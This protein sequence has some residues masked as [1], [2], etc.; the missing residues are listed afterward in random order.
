MS[1]PPVAFSNVMWAP[2]DKYGPLI[3]R[4][5]GSG[6]IAHNV[7][8]TQP[9]SASRRGSMDARARSTLRPICIATANSFCVSTEHEKKA[10]KSV[11]WLLDEY[12]FPAEDSKTDNTRMPVPVRSRSSTTKPTSHPPACRPFHLLE[13]PVYHPDDVRT[14]LNGRLLK[15]LN[16]VVPLGQAHPIMSTPAAYIQHEVYS[17][18]HE[19]ADISMARLAFIA[20]NIP[21]VLRRIRRLTNNVLVLS[22]PATQADA[23]RLLELADAARQIRKASV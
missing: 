4:R 15:T 12:K 10:A 16:D 11:K 14:E 2:S 22:T 18:A 6:T 7:R 20:D 3:T 5:R 23:D 1:G 9:C 8:G 21:D 17:I 13:L 19:L